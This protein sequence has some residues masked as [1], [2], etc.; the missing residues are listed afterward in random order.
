MPSIKEPD[1]AAKL[2]LWPVTIV[3][4]RYRGTYTGGNWIA[5]ANSS[6]KRMEELSPIFEDD[7]TAAAFTLP[8]WAVA[9]DTPDLAL[10]NLR[11]SIARQMFPE[12]FVQTSNDHV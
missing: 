3:E 4:D 10:E 1:W 2:S 5:V 7:V 12:Y 6:L 8:A 11:R 9:G